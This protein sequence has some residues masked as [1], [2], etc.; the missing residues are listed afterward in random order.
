MDNRDEFFADLEQKQEAALQQAQ[1]EVTHLTS[2]AQH[3]GWQY[4]MGLIK[5]DI[6]LNTEGLLNTTHM[7]SVMRLQERVK[8]KKDFLTWLEI[9]VA[10]RDYLVNEQKALAS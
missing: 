10:E 8:A 9:K 5:K 1:V 6:E 7:D 4:I 3:P 2:L